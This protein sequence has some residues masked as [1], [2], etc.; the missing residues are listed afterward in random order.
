MLSL[1][2]QRKNGSIYLP[3][4]PFHA[5]AVAL[6]DRDL[7]TVTR[8]LQIWF[9]MA[10]SHESA[11]FYEIKERAGLGLLV[12]NLLHLVEIMCFQV[13]C[14]NRQKEEKNLSY[15]DAMD[16]IL[17]EGTP[18][19]ADI[20]DIKNPTL[21]LISFT[22]D[23]SLEF[24]RNELWILFD[25]VRFYNG[26]LNACISADDTHNTWQFLSCVTEAA[27]I[28]TTRRYQDLAGEW[29]YPTPPYGY[30]SPKRTG[31]QGPESKEI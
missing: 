13:E 24:I 1:E 9:F 16:K 3:N 28:V 29:K 5:I 26:P 2:D 27:Y 21:W 8:E 22:K 14:Q 11:K 23:F 18:Y 10:V 25:A 4:E 17:E 6:E 31:N 12:Y 20:T 30:I 7:D 19:W 15:N